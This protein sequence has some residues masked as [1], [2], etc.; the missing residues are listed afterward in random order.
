MKTQN[1][2]LGKYV[3]ICTDFGWKLYFGP[4]Q[5][6]Q[7]LI[8]FL[9]SLF[10]GEKVIKDL[11]YRATERQAEREGGRKV[12]F[13]LYCTSEDNSHFIIEMQQLAQ[14]FIKDRMVYYSSR[15]I[16]SL[17]PRGPRG[18]S[19]E[20][21]EVYLIGILDFSL[22][23]SL[24]DKYYNDVL[25]C[26]KDSKEIF[27]DKLG[28]KLLCLPNFQKKGA[29]VKSTMDMWLYLFKYMNALNEMPKFL[30]KRV[31]RLIFELGAVSNLTVDDMRAYEWSLKDKRD[32]ESIRITAE[33]AA[34][35]QMEEGMKTGLAKGM[36][37]GLAEGLEKGMEKGLAEG[38]EKGIAQGMKKGIEK[39]IEK[40][41]HEVVN[42]LI[43]RGDCSDETIADI[44][45]VS[46]EFVQAMRKE[47]SPSKQ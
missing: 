13:D 21:P 39:G 9:N 18:N 33:R 27:Y 7:N 29:E 31:F 28:Y 24:P 11:D 35:R 12:I 17:V 43:V 8:S 41:K 26:D 10:D 4:E 38:M 46:L 16:H 15:L 19:Y 6:K 1:N 14:E 47:L 30:D 36:E 22:Q 34:L 40:N 25:L 20:L 42:K 3:D 2:L 44:V 23:G 45:D 32:A 37:K 5:G